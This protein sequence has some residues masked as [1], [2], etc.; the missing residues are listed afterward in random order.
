MGKIL[1]FDGFGAAFPHLCLAKGAEILS[2]PPC[3]ISRLSEQCV[4]LR[5]ELSKRNIGINKWMNSANRD[6]TW[7]T[8]KDT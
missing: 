2:S 3:Q 4:A 1:N 6:A 5:R 7:R 8:A